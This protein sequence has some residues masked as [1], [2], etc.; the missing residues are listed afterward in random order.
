MLQ[1]GFMCKYGHNVYSA[2]SSLSCEL[3]CH[4]ERMIVVCF[5][6]CLT[7][8]SPPVAVPLRCQRSCPSPSWHT[9]W[10]GALLSRRGLDLQRRKW[11]DWQIQVCLINSYKAVPRQLYHCD[12]SLWGD[13]INISFFYPHTIFIPPYPWRQ[14]KVG[15]IEHVHS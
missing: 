6:S 5:W 13:P 2:E 3:K 12:G 4:A 10:A 1:T 7:P 8:P 15:R 9:Q 14:Q 11:L